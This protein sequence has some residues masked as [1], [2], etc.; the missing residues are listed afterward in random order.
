MLHTASHGDFIK[1][2]NPTYLELYHRLLGDELGANPSEADKLHLQ[3]LRAH[4][5]LIARSC[6][7]E[8]NVAS[9]Q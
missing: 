7:L 6:E 2:W 9:M 5:A 8:R 3:L 1:A 4:Q